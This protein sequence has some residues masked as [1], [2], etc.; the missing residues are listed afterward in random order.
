MHFSQQ[1]REFGSLSC[2]IKKPDFPNRAR[3]L[4]HPWMDSEQAACGSAG[5]ELSGATFW[6]RELLLSA[7]T[8]AEQ[9]KQHWA[10]SWAAPKGTRSTKGEQQKGWLSRVLTSLAPWDPYCSG[11]PPDHC[12]DAISSHQNL[13]RYPGSQWEQ[14][15]LPRRVCLSVAFV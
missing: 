3:A 12:T 4:T 10:K 11:D 5:V 14:D 1:L 7:F 2:A 15:L 9:G 13:E 8:E 6:G